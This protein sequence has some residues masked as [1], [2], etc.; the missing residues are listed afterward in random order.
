VGAEARYH[1]RM[2]DPAREDGTMLGVRNAK[3]LMSGS[4]RALSQRSGG[5]TS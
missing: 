1:R 2:G 3:V 4:W 5:R